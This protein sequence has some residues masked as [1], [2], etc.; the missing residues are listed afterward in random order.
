[1][2]EHNQER[3]RELGIKPIVA[4]EFTKPNVGEKKYSKLPESKGKFKRLKK[5]LKY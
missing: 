3:A 5:S 1:M 2:L 4:K